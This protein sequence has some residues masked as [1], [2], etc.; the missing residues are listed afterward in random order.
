MVHT[1]N[2]SKVTAM[3]EDNTAIIIFRDMSQR[4]D[5]VHL[6][7]EASCSDKA[8]TSLVSDIGSLAK[9]S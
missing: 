3:N 1:G 6:S 4:K 2:N 9:M 7:L 8:R 5:K